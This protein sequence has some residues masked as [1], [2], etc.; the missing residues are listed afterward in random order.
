MDRLNFTLL[1]RH[2]AALRLYNIL[3]SLPIAKKAGDNDEY[4]KRERQL[5][6]KLIRQ[7]TREYTK[8]LNALPEK[9][10]EQ[11]IEILNENLEKTLG[12][13]FGDSEKIKKFFHDYI[14]K[15]YKASKREFAPQANLSLADK[16]AVDVLTKHNCFWIG[17]HYGSHIGGKIAEL[18]QQALNNGLGRKELAK[19]LKS[20]L[21]GKVGGYK[22]WDVA[23]SAA[24]VR[25]RSFGAISGMEEAGIAEY[26]ILAMQ[27]ERM[28]PI[29]GEMDGQ[30]FSVAITRERINSVLNIKDP[31]A[32]KQAMPWHTES[33]KGLSRETLQNSGMNLP[34]F[35]GRCRCTLVSVAETFEHV[36][37]P[38]DIGIEEISE[39]V[40]F[41]AGNVAD[42][43]LP[44]IMS[45]YHIEDYG[46]RININFDNNAIIGEDTYAYVPRKAT[47]EEREKAV[48]EAVKKHRPNLELAALSRRNGFATF[49][50]S[51]KWG[52]R[53]LSDAEKKQADIE[54]ED[55]IKQLFNSPLSQKGRELNESY[56]EHEDGGWRRVL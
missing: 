6:A 29:C 23:S 40:E 55:Y 48:I 12:K 19:E 44:G 52:G 7:W 5:A 37:I 53:L 10:T 33:P 27:D 46:S 9:I 30:A 31:E 8:I 17:E 2:E 4:L 24:L 18:T 39:P 41:P 50:M 22:Y 49:E 20:A 38:A 25:A 36:A 45:E 21:G 35:H 14:A 26:E 43:S 56:W 42:M 3:T 32:F 15:T 54:M 1:Q 16:K 28:C 34:P 51:Q 11:V 47:Q 13:G